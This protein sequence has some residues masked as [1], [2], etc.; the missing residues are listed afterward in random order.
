LYDSSEG[1][2]LTWN[3]NPEVDIDHY[4][5]WRM[6]WWSKYNYTAWSKIA[7]TAD[8]CYLDTGFD[9]DPEGGTKAKYRIRAEDEMANLSPYSSIVSTWGTPNEQKLAVDKFTPSQY[10]LSSNFPNPFN[11]ETEIEYALPEVSWVTLKVYNILGQVVEVLVDSEQRAG[12]HEIQ[13][14]GEGVSSGVYFYRLTAGEF[15]DT[16]RMV[17][18]K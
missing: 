5:V 9:P 8:T 15:T 11:P 7:E 1:S 4:E 6:Y 17:L 16:K 10:S 13:W 18:M 12:Y 14:N 3:P 2:Y